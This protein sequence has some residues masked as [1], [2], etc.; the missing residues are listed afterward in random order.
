MFNQVKGDLLIIFRLFSQG[1][2]FLVEGP[3]AMREREGSCNTAKAVLIN[4]HTNIWF[5]H[6]EFL[7]LLYTSML[8][9]EKSDS[10]M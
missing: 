2:T 5:Y 6:T 7:L 4:P 9:A 10:P 1:N 8:I 3:V